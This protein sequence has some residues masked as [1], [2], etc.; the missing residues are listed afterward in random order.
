MACTVTV[1]RTR[2]ILPHPTVSPGNKCLQ[3]LVQP[4]ALCYILK[5]KASGMKAIQRRFLCQ[6]KFDK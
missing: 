6:E 5:N 2:Q 4:D 1:D 3:T